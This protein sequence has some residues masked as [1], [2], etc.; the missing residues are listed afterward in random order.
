VPPARAGVAAPR[1]DQAAASPGEEAWP[2]YDC[3]TPVPVPTRIPA[4]F[5]DN[6]CLNPNESC[7][8]QQYKSMPY[9]QVG[10]AMIGTSAAAERTQKFSDED[11]LNTG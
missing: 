6:L 5:A 9:S 8:A 2:M 7:L 11:L 1:R 10:P 4:M 3:T